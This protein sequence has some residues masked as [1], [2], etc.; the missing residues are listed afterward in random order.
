M[1]WGVPL[2]RTDGPRL[3]VFTRNSRRGSNFRVSLSDNYVPANFATLPSFVHTGLPQFTTLH[4]VF[5]EANFMFLIDIFVLGH[6][7]SRGVA[8]TKIKAGVT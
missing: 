7:C 2:P 6:R 4:I 3:R 8:G 5:V 1:P